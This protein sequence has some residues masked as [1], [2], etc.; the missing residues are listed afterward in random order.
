[1]FSQRTA[2]GKRTPVIA[3]AIVVLVA[4]IAVLIAVDQMNPVGNPGS[5]TILKPS[6]PTTTNSSITSNPSATTTTLYPN[7]GGSTTQTTGNASTPCPSDTTCASSFTYDSS[8]NQVRVNSVQA[9]E[10]ACHN[11]GAVNGQPYVTFAVNFENIGLP[12]PSACSNCEATI[13]IEAGTGGL[14]VSAYPSSVLQSVPSQQCVG[15]ST[16]VALEYGQNYTMYGPGCDT[17]F[18]YQLVQAGSVTLTFLIHWTMSGQASGTPE[19]DTVITAQF[20]FA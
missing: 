1:M 17:G 9:T 2:I 3:A 19:L 20:S 14:I 4:G 18:D 10:Y 11:C 13:D 6:Q 7:P 5:R 16:I 15:T 8:V 12:H